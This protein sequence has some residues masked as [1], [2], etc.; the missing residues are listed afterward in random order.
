M[1]DTKAKTIIILPGA[2][3]EQAAEHLRHNYVRKTA[4]LE[5]VILEMAKSELTV[6]L[7]VVHDDWCQVFHQGIC[8]CDPDIIANGKKIG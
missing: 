4:A 1:S 2:S 6:T 3:D 7:D 8:N 5:A